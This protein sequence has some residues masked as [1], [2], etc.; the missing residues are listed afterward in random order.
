[1]KVHLSTADLVQS[2]REFLHELA[3]AV[4]TSNLYATLYVE[5]G[6]PAL[7]QSL[8]ESQSEIERLIQVRR[9][10]ILQLSPT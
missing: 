1:M 5:R 3:G 9:E 7:L 8:Q 6:N 4:A 2:E 10:F